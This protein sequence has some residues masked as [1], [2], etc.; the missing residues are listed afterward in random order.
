MKNQ[1]LSNISHDLRNYIWG[2]NGLAHLVAECIDSCQKM[3]TEKEGNIN[4]SLK[5]ASELIHILEPYSKEAID[6][7]DDMLDTTQIET[8][9]FTIGRI[10]DCD[11]EKLINRLLIFNK[12]LL[13]KN[14]V[15]AHTQ[16]E[17]NLPHLQCDVRRLKQILMNLITNA[18]KYSSENSIIKLAV[19]SENNK[20]YIKITDSGIG[21]NE[22]E[23]EM[24]LVGNGVTIDKSTLD[25]PFDSHGL[26]LPIVKQLMELMGKMTI[27]SK[28]GRG[29]KIVLEFAC[30]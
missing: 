23:L 14:K 1:S 8:G 7:I 27:E 9:E 28:R 22:A 30:A 5:E 25:K 2:I 11:I 13:I 15:T 6:Y 20:I 21:M 29:T 16:I 3:I 18:A 24:A 12:T 17:P 26:G 19:H 10:E 4:N